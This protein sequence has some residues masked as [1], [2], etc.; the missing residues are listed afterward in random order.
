MRSCC[1]Y[2]W[3][4]QKTRIGQSFWLMCCPLERIKIVT[5]TTKYEPVKLKSMF[6]S[7]ERILNYWKYGISVV[8]GLEFTLTRQC[9]KTK[10]KLLKQYS[11][12][13]EI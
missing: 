5:V 6:A 12:F 4:K 10:Y 3:G 2:F 8:H 13:D 9:L 1:K 11:M 7:F